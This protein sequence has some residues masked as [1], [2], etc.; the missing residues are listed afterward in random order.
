MRLSSAISASPSVE[1][2]GRRSRRL[3]IIVRY[4]IK[5]NSPV[6]V[7]TH[8]RGQV[9]ETLTSHGSTHCGWN[10]WSQ[11]RTLT[12]SPTV[13]SSVQM[14]QPTFSS[15]TGSDDDVRVSWGPLESAVSGSVVFVVFASGGAF[16]CRVASVPG[17]FGVGSVARVPSPAALSSS[18]SGSGLVGRDESPNL[19]MGMVSRTAR[20]RPLARLC[21]GLPPKLGLGPYLSG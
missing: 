7:G 8:H 20:A 13:K 4:Q 17:S 3:G 16:S 5:D 18:C 9:P 15:P 14:E 1:D 11:G 21:L 6:E 12:S 2:C 19:T 10:L